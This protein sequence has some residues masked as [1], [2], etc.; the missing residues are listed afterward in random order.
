M[1]EMKDLGFCLAEVLASLKQ[2]DA[3]MAVNK[4]Q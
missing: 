2:K 1:V 4:W 3:Q